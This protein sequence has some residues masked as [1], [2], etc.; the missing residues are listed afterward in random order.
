[1]PLSPAQ[2]RH[3][4]KLA[5]LEISDAEVEK[6]SRELSSILSYIEKLKEVD[7]TGVEPT[8]QVTGLTNAFREDVI[9]PQGPTTAELLATSPLPIEEQQIETPSAHG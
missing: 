6:Y 7:T 5:R 2:V 3:I 8:A 4:A 1:M 9:A